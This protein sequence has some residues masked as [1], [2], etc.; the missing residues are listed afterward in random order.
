LVRTPIA[1]TSNPEAASDVEETEV[2]PRAK[3]KRE[4]TS[5]S[6]PK[7]PRGTPS[8]KFTKNLEKEKILLKEI[9]TRRSKQGGIEHFFAK[10]RY[11]SIFRL[12]FFIF[13]I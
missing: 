5:G 12:P 9:D 10:A 4:T 7:L 2:I 6:K 13:K 3:R 11:R 8:A 1:G